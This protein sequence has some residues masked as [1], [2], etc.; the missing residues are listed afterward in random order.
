MA[1]FLRLI[2]KF[3]RTLTLLLLVCAVSGAF[4]IGRSLGA[5]SQAQRST[6]P[7]MS[8]RSDS[9]PATISPQT[10][11]SS[12]S[13]TE[14]AT[15]ARAI[16]NTQD[17]G[18][19]VP[20]ADVYEEAL[21]NVRRNFVEIDAFPLTK[22]DTDGLARM[23]ASLGDPRTHAL[24]IERCKARRASLEGNYAGIGAVL[25]VTR[26]RRADVDYSHLTV[27]AVM[28]GSP[29]EKA[30]LH[31]G[32]NITEIDGRWII[33][34][35]IYA[36]ADRIGREKGVNDSARQAEMAEVNH[37]FRAGL[38]LSRALDY[39]ELGEGA[40]HTL[41]IERPLGKLV[42]RSVG[43][44][45]SSAAA[46]APILKVA[47]TTASTRVTPVTFRILDSKA[48]RKE[49]GR[50]EGGR[51][52][53]GRKVGYLRIRQFNARATAA[54]EKSLED[55]KGLDGLVIDLRENPGGVVAE[56]DAA[57]DGFASARRLIGLLTGGGTV[58][59]LE[60]RRSQMDPLTLPTSTTMRTPGVPMVV[61]V[62]GG[63][64]NLAELTAAALRDAG[65][66][67]LLGAHTF[68]DD[69][70]QMFAQ[71][72]SGAG[73]EL[74]TAHL[75]TLG[76]V[77]LARGVEPDV[78]SHDVNEEAMLDQASAMLVR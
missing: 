20:P 47:I 51:K 3:A 24:T 72:K 55:V 35:T 70:L 14:C 18:M 5:S 61:L 29:A 44:S 37:K 32:D 40:T 69:V 68:G 11:A 66:A 71:F 65:K 45:G 73:V 64:A 59:R 12:A 62:D 53:G 4:F 60:R 16:T 6:P 48:G 67:R 21:T 38:S 78:I 25:G 8:T 74:S 57:V 52:E 50:K 63:T 19:N 27:V 39:L 30:G 77:D 42:E 9:A 41:S 23:Y 22:L 43:K 54:F 7:G 28:P 46:V 1:L 33:N 13:A 2:H 56:A 26:T 75:F 10:A 58:A 31:A 76:R 49:G 36:D 17:S 34:Y 15:S